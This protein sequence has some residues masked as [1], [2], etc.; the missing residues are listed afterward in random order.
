MIMF[1]QGKSCSDLGRVLATQFWWGGQT[2]MARGA[3]WSRS[4]SQL[5]L[6]HTFF[7]LPCTA[8]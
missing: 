3:V 1:T 4:F 2:G 5:T 7:S 8:G 6:A